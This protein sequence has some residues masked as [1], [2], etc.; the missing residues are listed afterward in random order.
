MPHNP[1]GIM[2]KT[3]WRTRDSSAQGLPGMS[4][5]LRRLPPNFLVTFF[6]Q[7]PDIISEISMKSRIYTSDISERDSK[8]TVPAAICR[9]NGSLS[10]FR[11]PACSAFGQKNCW[12]SCLL[13]L[14]LPQQPSPLSGDSAALPAIPQESG[15]DT[16][17][18]VCR[19]FCDRDNELW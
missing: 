12:P 6:Q 11:Q 3:V 18:G 17:P 5:T 15:W 4:R 16:F 14:R 9:H 2:I 8:K 13:P 19:T 10:L 7:I 1:S